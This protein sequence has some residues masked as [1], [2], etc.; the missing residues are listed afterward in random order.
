M[1]PVRV[2]LT[3]RDRTY[4]NPLGTSDDGPKQRLPCRAGQLLRIV[5]QRQRA[6]TV[7]PQTGVVEQDARDD[8]RSSKRASTRLVR[9]CDK[10]RAEAT[11]KR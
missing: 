2:D 1:E 7:V 9:P 11:I 5:E 8:E 3:R 10:P 4:G 6:D